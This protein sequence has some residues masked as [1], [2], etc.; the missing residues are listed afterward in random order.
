MKKRSKVSAEF[1]MS[2]LTDIIFLLLIFFMLTSSMVIPNALNL[3]LPGKS[4]K[5]T[6]QPKFPPTEVKIDKRGNYYLNGDKASR[7]DIERVVIA[8]K[9]ERTKVSLIIVPDDNTPT[10][11][12]VAI[13]DIAYRYHI[14]A[15]MTD[16][17]A[18]APIK[19]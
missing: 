10:E 18:K 15:I 7:R 14:D 13:L 5:V 12:V 16:P 8:L 6:N 11:K 19:G 2:S 4:T 3:K 17:K 9:K 1:S